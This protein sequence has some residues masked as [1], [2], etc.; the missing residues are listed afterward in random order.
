MIGS[1]LMSSVLGSFW[2][3]DERSSGL[4][5]FM[6][7]PRCLILDGEGMDEGL[8]INHRI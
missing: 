5:I 8:W 1:Y 4:I 6:S 3:L 7:L 2:V